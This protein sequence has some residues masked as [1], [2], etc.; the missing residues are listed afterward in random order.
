MARLLAG[1]NPQIAK[2]YGD[3]PV[4]DWI[5]AA[6]GWKGSHMRALDAL[7][8]ALV[9]DVQKA[10]KWN[11]PLYGSGGDHW[12]LGVHA[13]ARYLK[14]AFYRGARLD[15]MPPVA[16]KRDDVRYLHLYEADA[17]D[18]AQLRDWITAAARLP[19][20]KM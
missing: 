1:E 18:T 10:V 2:G 17:V 15:P 7:I 8:V 3:A 4:Q 9:P 11:S 13:V 6:P 5:I 20:L 16:S 14:V 19:G 12:F